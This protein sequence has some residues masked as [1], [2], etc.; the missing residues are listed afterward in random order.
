M[1]IRIKKP[2]MSL[3]LPWIAQDRSFPLGLPYLTW[4]ES[5]FSEFSE[6]FFTVYIFFAYAK[7]RVAKKRNQP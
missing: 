4:I 3:R 6:F 1:Q 5:E 2:D 7:L